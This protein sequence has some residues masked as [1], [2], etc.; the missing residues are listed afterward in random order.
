MSDRAPV[1]PL[2]V[3]ARLAFDHAAEWCRPDHGCAS[4]HRA[5]SLVRLVDLEGELPVGHAFL[6]RELPPLAR[7]KALR[8]LIAGAADSGLAA[9]VLS[10]LQPFGIM[11]E[12]L[13]VDRCETPLA[14]NR[15]LAEA[16]SVR[17]DTLQADVADLPPGDFDAVILHNVLFF[18]PPDRRQAFLAGAGRALRPGGRLLAVQRLQDGPAR[19]LPA[20]PVSAADPALAARAQSAA[21]DGFADGDAAAVAAAL[22]AFRTHDSPRW[23]VPAEDLHAQLAVAGFGPV[24][25]A[26]LEDGVAASPRARAGRSAAGQ[27][28]CILAEKL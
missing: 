12:I 21:T 14:Q 23:T 18:V 17:I 5:W 24:T 9:L 19:L 8:V 11:P 16:V 27:R 10:A 28:S 26:P 15:H 20:K 7:H 3:L 2:A 6:A 22:E 1:E 13:V 4:Y 25:I